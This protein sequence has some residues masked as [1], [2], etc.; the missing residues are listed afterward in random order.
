MLTTSYKIAKH[1]GVNFYINLI[2]SMDM[3]E[4]LKDTHRLEVVFKTGYTITVAA[5]RA[6]KT[7]TDKMKGNDHLNFVYGYMP[8]SKKSIETQNDYVG[9]HKYW[10]DL[11]GQWPKQTV[12][13]F[14]KVFYDFYVKP[15]EDVVSLVGY[16]C[17]GIDYNSLFDIIQNID[18]LRQVLQDG[19]KHVLPLCQTFNNNTH[20]LKQM[21]GKSLWK[22]LCKNSFT[23]NK[24]IAQH[25]IK[26]YR[27][28]HGV[29]IVDI[30]LRLNCLKYKHLASFFKGHRLGTN[31][32]NMGYFP[33][34]DWC[35]A[36]DWPKNQDEYHTLSNYAYDTAHMSRRVFGTDATRELDR[37]KTVDDLF[38]LHDYCVE[39]I[40]KGRKLIAPS[41]STFD[42]VKNLELAGVARTY[43]NYKLTIVETPKQLHELGK[44]QRHCVYSYSHHIGAGE[45]LVGTLSDSKGVCATIGW[46]IDDKYKLPAL[47][48]AYGK[49]NSKLPQEV[50]DLVDTATNDLRI[51]TAKNNL[52]LCK[53][54]G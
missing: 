4:K 34:V 21:F 36:W 2:E 11:T 16:R 33:N 13:M 37:V 39:N 35:V 43:G 31:I 18:M 19:N 28:S 45:Y 48:Q 22:K 25:A 49:C 51:H 14:K 41:E 27:N 1:Q 15:Y 7:I 47:D 12:K 32:R 26:F 20:G 3:S 52:K 24:K 6:I 50:L 17:Y 23:R 5:G 53:N 38:E 54:T 10:H 42:F 40:N 9:A 44:D 30:V 29:H 8:E 46:R